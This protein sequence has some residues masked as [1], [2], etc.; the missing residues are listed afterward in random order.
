MN[1][2]IRLFAGYRE[3]VGAS[4]IHLE[5]PEGA[6]LQ[7]AWDALVTQYPTLGTVRHRVVGSVN[8]EYVPLD[9]VLHD[10]ADATHCG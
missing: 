2:V 10:E 5:L 4:T 6:T 3:R 9:H 7:T 8:A 1:V